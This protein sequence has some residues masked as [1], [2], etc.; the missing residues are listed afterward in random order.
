MGAMMQ[1]TTVNRELMTT[2]R[3]R[4]GYDYRIR[5]QNDGSALLIAEGRISDGK[6]PTRRLNCVDV[7][8]AMNMAE[9]VERE[10]T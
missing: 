2:S 5:E 7:R 8:H 4:S 9:Q 6:P 1:W 3:Q 10:T